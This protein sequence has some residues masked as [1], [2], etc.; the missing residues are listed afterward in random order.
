MGKGRIIPFKNAVID[1][2]ENSKIIIYDESIEI[3]TEA[4]NNSK[5]ETYVRLR[6]NALWEAC[7]SCSINYGCTVEVLEKAVLKTDYFTMNS[8]STIVCAKSISIGHD[9][10]IAR[11]VVLYDSD[12]HAILDE[13]G[14][15]INESEGVSIG[16]HVWIGTNSMILKGVK[17][18]ANSII[19]AGTIVKSMVEKNTII[20]SGTIRQYSGTWNR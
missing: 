16:E 19:G 10:M 3:G 2:E 12:F 15:Q 13:K 6:K 5:A 4:L 8:Q 11:N 20:T 18:G 17:I 1:L 7:E 9:V 14:N